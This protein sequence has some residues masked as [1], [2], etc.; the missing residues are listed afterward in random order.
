MQ[1]VAA[2]IVVFSHFQLFCAKIWSSYKN[3]CNLD[4][5]TRQCYEDNNL[6]ETVTYGI[7]LSV[8][9]VALQ[10]GHGAQS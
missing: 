5:Q 8:S 2:T 1:R 3:W 4:V 7:F 10:V 9:L 6:S